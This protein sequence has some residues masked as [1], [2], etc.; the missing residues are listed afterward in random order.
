MST[1]FSHLSHLHLSFAC[2]SLLWSWLSHVSKSALPGW[3]QLPPSTRSGVASCDLDGRCIPWGGNLGLS[4]AT[5]TALSWGG[6]SG[7]SGSSCCLIWILDL[8][9]GWQRLLLSQ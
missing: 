7:V 5:V 3:A 6:S 8:H 1:P 4:R 9:M 2:T